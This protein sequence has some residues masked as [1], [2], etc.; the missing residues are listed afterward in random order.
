MSGAHDTS[1]SDTDAETATDYAALVGLDADHAL[2]VVARRCATNGA[3][4]RE[5]RWLEER[6]AD[7]RLV[8]RYR[9]WTVRS[10]R[11][12]YRCELGWER[13]SLAGTLLDREVR[14]STRAS[15]LA[16]N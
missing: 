8:A 9:T 12:P 13:F 14:Y 5:T 1:D 2:A 7:A 16:L 4:R 6:D 10:S 11:A 15:R 3:T